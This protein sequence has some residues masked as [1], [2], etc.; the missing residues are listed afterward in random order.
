VAD[1]AAAGAVE[2][3]EHGQALIGDAVRGLGIV[4]A[5][6]LDQAFRI[7]LTYSVDQLV[8]IA[9]RAWKLHLD[10]ADRR[11]APLGCQT[12]Q[13]ALL[14]DLIAEQLLWLDLPEQQFD[15]QGEELDVCHADGDINRGIR[16]SGQA[17]RSP[18]LE[19]AE[20]L[21]GLF[22][23]QDVTFVPGLKEGSMK[24]SRPLRANPRNAQILDQLF[25][26]LRGRYFCSTYSAQG[27]LSFGRL[28]VNLTEVH[29]DKQ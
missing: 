17:R 4:A 21:S 18:L 27:H 7:Q 22:Q 15:A 28:P 3:A 20:L 25:D 13:D 8:L 23:S 19:F 10:L 1:L 26:A 16:A 29:S 14:G 11:Y 6:V 12:A 5:N 2:P 9:M 24:L